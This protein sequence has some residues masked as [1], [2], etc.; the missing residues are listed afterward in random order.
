MQVGAVT[1]DQHS[2]DNPDMVQ[3][4]H[5]VQYRGK[6]WP[7]Y[8]QPGAF[9]FTHPADPG[10]TVSGSQEMHPDHDYLLTPVQVNYDMHAKALDM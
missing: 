6:N 10:D 4:I 8:L 3:T 2:S 7:M 9:V 5:A 1:T